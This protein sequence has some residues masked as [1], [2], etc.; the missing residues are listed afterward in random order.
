MSHRVLLTG[1]TGFVGGNVASVL[2]GRGADV[3][4]AV[5]R[6]PGPDFPW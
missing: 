1:G 2:A 3:L 6:D 5:R 4:C